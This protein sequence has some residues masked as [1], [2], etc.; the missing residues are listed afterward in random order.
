MTILD[1]SLDSND[2]NNCV[3]IV[4]A[5]GEPR[6]GPRTPSATLRKGYSLHGY[7]LLSISSHPLTLRDHRDGSVAATLFTRIIF[8]DEVTGKLI[9]FTDKG[10]NK[11]HRVKLP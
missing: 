3:R 7:R 8:R 11:F 10:S 4:Y 2:P 9:E 5:G 6:G 1:V